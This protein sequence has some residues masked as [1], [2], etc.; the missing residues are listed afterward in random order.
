MTQASWTLSFLKLF[1]LTSTQE[2]GVQSPF[3]SGTT[4]ISAPI[5][6]IIL[7]PQP[8]TFHFYF[9]NK[10]PVLTSLCFFF[11]YLRAMPTCVSHSSPRTGF[12]NPKACFQPDIMCPPRNAN[13]H[14]PP[15]KCSCHKTGEPESNQTTSLHPPTGNITSKWHRGEADECRMW[16]ILRDN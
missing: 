7:S 15:M 16:D 4:N 10:E 14:T 12:R 1:F 5:S 2:R 11:L 13:A 6:P 9:R 3:L 8:G